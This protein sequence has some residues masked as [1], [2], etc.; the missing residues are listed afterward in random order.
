MTGQCTSLVPQWIHYLTTYP[1][2]D[3]NTQSQ[4]YLNLK[5][6][7]Y[8]SL[9]LLPLG[10]SAATYPVYSQVVTAVARTAS[11]REPRQQIR[12]ASSRVRRCVRR[13]IMVF[14]VALGVGDTTLF[15]TH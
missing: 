13:A 15:P 4:G 5:L 14:P 8:G 7:L 1:I 6:Y 11:M 10:N 12:W 2:Y 3:S 9:A